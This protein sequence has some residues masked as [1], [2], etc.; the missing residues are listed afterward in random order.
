MYVYSVFGNIRCNCK[1]VVFVL[2]FGTSISFEGFSFWCSQ[3]SIEWT[4]TGLMDFSCKIFCWT[5]FDSA[6]N[7]LVVPDSSISSM[8]MVTV[9]LACFLLLVAHYGAINIFGALWQ[10]LPYL[11]L[12]KCQS[13]PD[14]W[15]VVFSLLGCWG[16]SSALLFV[17]CVMY[18]CRC[19]IY[20]HMNICLCIRKLPI[21]SYCF[22]IFVKSKWWL[23]R[24]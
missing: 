11:N 8:T 2:P 20:M 17:A 16:L 22:V 19:G 3:K 14:V 6:I 12:L 5:D 1:H 4:H 23:L 13:F 24:E 15:I 18:T 9:L 10:N 21:C 7:D